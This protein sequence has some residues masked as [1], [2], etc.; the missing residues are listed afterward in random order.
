MN[1]ILKNC[2]RN[3]ANTQIFTYVNALKTFQLCSVLWRHMGLPLLVV[4]QEVFPGE[5]ANQQRLKGWI[6]PGGAK[7]KGKYSR[8]QGNPGKGTLSAGETEGQC[9]AGTWEARSR[10]MWW[11]WRGKPDEFVTPV[12]DLDLNAKCGRK[13]MKKI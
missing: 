6:G 11:S 3:K 1:K 9:G 2:T 7:T 12:K 5:E 10:T 8:R 4:S 13:V